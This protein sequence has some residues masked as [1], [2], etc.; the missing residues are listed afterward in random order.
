LDIWDERKVFGSH[1][2]AL[3]EEL[4]GKKSNN[5]SEDAKGTSYKLVR[6]FFPC[7]FGEEVYS[8]NI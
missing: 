6:I 3:K 7:R 1:G 8:Y 4:F 5:Q 2:Q